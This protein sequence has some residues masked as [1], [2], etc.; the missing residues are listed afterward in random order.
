MK[1]ALLTTQR[2]LTLE[3]T[4][5]KATNSKSESTPTTVRRGT[6]SRLDDGGIRA[7]FTTVPLTLEISNKCQPREA[8]SFLCL[9][10][11]ENEEAV[12]AECAGA[13]VVLIS[14]ATD[15]VR[16][17]DTIVLEHTDV[18]VISHKLGTDK[19]W[20]TLVTCNN[21]QF[22]TILKRLTAIRTDIPSASMVVHWPVGR[23]LPPPHCRAI[24]KGCYNTHD[25]CHHEVNYDCEFEL[26]GG[27][28]RGGPQ[29]LLPTPNP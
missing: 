21:H 10:H 8:S 26:N 3:L 16:I 13:P 11:G 17:I 29:T 23:E 24:P 28:A 19:K 2:T 1:A 20:Y 6:F 9:E 27:L 5:K 7:T 22:F 12:N 18:D 14:C 15:E 4:Q 25:H